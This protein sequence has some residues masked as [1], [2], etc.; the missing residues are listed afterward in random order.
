MTQ[1]LT[2]SRWQL[3]GIEAAGLNGGR[4]SN[5]PSNIGVFF[6][7]ADKRSEGWYWVDASTN[8]PKGPF[9]TKTQAIENAVL[10]VST[11]EGQ[12]TASP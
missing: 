3:G 5:V 9:E 8:G 2:R 11:A 4:M 7:K 6:G 10:C 12:R 1:M